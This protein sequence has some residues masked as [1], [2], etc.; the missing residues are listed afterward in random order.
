[1]AVGFGGLLRQEPKRTKGTKKKDA[2]LPVT[3]ALCACGSAKEYGKCCRMFHTGQRVPRMAEELL[4]ARYTAYAFELPTFIMQ[5]T[6]GSE[7]EKDRKAWRAEILKFC[8]TF[9]FDEGVEVLELTMTGPHSTTILF[10]YD[11]QNLHAGGCG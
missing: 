10:R 5:T 9:Q 6:L 8:K 3:D 7:R 4:R 1:M 2:G 11:M